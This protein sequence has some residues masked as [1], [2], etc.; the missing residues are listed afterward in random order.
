MPE[1]TTQKKDSPKCEQNEK[2][3]KSDEAEVTDK[4][5]NWSTDQ[6]NK[7]Y[8]YDDSHGYEIYDPNAEDDGED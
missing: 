1:N 8:Y 7:G 3:K 6:Q 2:V 4:T 5:G